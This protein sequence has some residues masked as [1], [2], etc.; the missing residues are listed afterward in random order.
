MSQ[1]DLSAI[2]FVKIKPQTTINEVVS[3]I[4]EKVNGCIRETYCISG[5]DADLAITVTGVEKKKL[6]DLVVELHLVD[7]VNGAWSAPVLSIEHRPVP[8]TLEDYYNN[9]KQ[10]EEEYLKPI[11]EFISESSEVLLTHSDN[12]DEIELRK[13]PK[14]EAIELIK[15]YIVKHLGC[16]TSDIIYDLTLDPDLVMECLNELEEKKKVVG[17]KIGN[18]A[19]T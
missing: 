7:G 3:K 15:A 8:L 12:S 16:R 17:K 2:I 4:K 9:Q 18:N 1:M 11:K 5:K 14:N 6:K 10:L 19:R 13:I